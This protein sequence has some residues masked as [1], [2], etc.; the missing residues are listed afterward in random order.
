MFLVDLIATEVPCQYISALDECI[1]NLKK[2]VD[3]LVKSI[4][5]DRVKVSS[6]SKS[7][8]LL[9]YTTKNIHNIGIV[10]EH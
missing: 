5:Y 6:T 2:K 9:P 1:S 8:F 4:K 7:D 10:G 3:R